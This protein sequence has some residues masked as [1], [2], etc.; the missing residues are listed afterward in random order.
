MIISRSVLS[1]V[2]T[3]TLTA[4][5]ATMLRAGAHRHSVRKA[6]LA[7]LAIAGCAGADADSAA[8]PAAVVSPA[9]SPR[10]SVT[11]RN[12]QHPEAPLLVQILPGE[13]G[14][15]G[16]VRPLA[17]LRIPARAG[18]TTVALDSLPAG[19]YAIRVMQDLDANG[20]LNT[21]LVG[22]PVEPWGISN[23]A[24]GR[25]GPPRWEDARFAFPEVTAQVITL[26]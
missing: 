12:V 2:L 23:D 13:A 20:E 14:F 9:E 24:L 10:L 18:S 19:E 5:N 4:L 25:F 22:L 7:G 17:A 3:S 15:A 26:R 21:N 1:A 11:I 16:E 6:L 8:D